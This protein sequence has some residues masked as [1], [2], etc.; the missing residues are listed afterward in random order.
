MLRGGRPDSWKGC[1]RP[2]VYG[3]VR[4]VAAELGG[5]QAQSFCELRAGC[6]GMLS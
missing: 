6:A 3:A 4:S 5:L 2:F 1:R